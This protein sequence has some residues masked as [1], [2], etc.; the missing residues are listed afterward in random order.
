MKILVISNYR[1]T[2]SVRP[3]AELFLGL[4]KSGVEV[5]IMTYGDAQYVEKFKS[6]GIRV[7]DFHP[8]KKL[9]KKEIKRIREELIEARPDIL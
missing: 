8:E 3:E 9:D 1:E 7:I 5:D 6:A 4:K 2:A